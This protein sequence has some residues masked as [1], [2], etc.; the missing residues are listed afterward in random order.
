MAAGREGSAG[1]WC[2]GGRQDGKRRTDD[3]GPPDTGGAEV[4]LASPVRFRTGAGY[5]GRGLGSS[6][7]CRRR[8]ATV[9]VAF[10]GRRR[11]R[12]RFPRSSA[13]GKD[14]GWY[15]GLRRVHRGRG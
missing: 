13:G 6:R 7:L 12:G 1:R 8:P 14:A 3:P 4:T 9:A 11:G 10:G 2:R 5:E 15:G